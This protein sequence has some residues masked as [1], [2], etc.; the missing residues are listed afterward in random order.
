[1]G[2]R[3]GS[4]STYAVSVPIPEAE[5]EDDETSPDATDGIGSIEFTREEDSGYYGM[6]PS[7]L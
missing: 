7:L 2:D 4:L 6:R 3:R 1:M 5:T